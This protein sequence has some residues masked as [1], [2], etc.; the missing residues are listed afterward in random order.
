MKKSPK[1]K[2][3]LFS[4]EDYNSGDGMVTS[5]WGPVFWFALH[6][7]SFNYPVKPTP[8]DKKHY[9]DFIISLKYILPCRSCRENLVKNFKKLPLTMSDMK[10]RESFSRYV[11]NLHELVNTMLKKKSNLTYEDVRDRFET[12]RAKCVVKSKKHVGCVQPFYGKKSK[13]VLKIIPRDKKEEPIQ[14]HR[15]CKLRRKPK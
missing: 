6:T 10:N 5:V 3:M 2:K 12:F 9:K 14:I 4:A 7:M 15:S 1:T 11:Y 13:C 8:E